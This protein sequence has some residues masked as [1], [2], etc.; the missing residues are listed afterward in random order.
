MPCCE[1]KKCF[2]A[3][4]LS[5]GFPQLLLSTICLRYTFP[6]IVQILP[7]VKVPPGKLRLQLWQALQECTI[8]TESRLVSLFSGMDS[9]FSSTPRPNHCAFFLFPT[10]FQLLSSS[11]LIP[12]TMRFQGSRLNVSFAHSHVTCHISTTHSTQGHVFP[13]PGVPPGVLLQAFMMTSQR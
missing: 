1:R 7:P 9:I 6:Q 8:P 10:N 3:P 4:T 11:L 2:S 5:L 13:S 12:D